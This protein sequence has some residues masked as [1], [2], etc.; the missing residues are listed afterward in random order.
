[1]L[2]ILSAFASYVEVPAAHLEDRSA[3]PPLAVAA[4]DRSHEVVRIHSG[5]EEPANAYAAVRYRD[6]WFW[7][8]DGDW[9]TKRALSAVMFFFTLGETGG[10][11]KLPQ[12]TIPA[13]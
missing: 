6:H 1:M 13:Q 10:T 7:I 4:G 9:Q 5:T 11:D 12:V 3:V 8:D 2:Q